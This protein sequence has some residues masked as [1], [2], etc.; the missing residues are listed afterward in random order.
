MD[1]KIDILLKLDFFEKRGFKFDKNYSKNDS[2]DELKYVLETVIYKYNKEQEDKVYD[3]FIKMIN[4]AWHQLE[5]HVVHQYAFSKNPEM[6]KERMQRIYN[7]GDE[8]LI[9]KITAIVA[10]VSTWDP[11]EPPDSDSD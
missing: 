8:K 11:Y 7:S 5:L 9:E 6:N 2:L 10:I 4:M 3:H 1:E